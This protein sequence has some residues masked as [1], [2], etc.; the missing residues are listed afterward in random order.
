MRRTGLRLAALAALLFALPMAVL[1][2][3]PHQ[4]HDVTITISGATLTA[5]GKEAGLGD[6]D[7]VHIV[8]TATASCVNPGNNKP[9]AANKET[10]TAEGDFP[11]Q[12]GKADFT[13]SVTAT[14]QPSCS[15]PMTVEFSDV[16]VVDTT[17]GI[18]LYP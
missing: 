15:P 14:F 5:S 11:V 4:V 1:A 16:T 12:N 9:Q 18:Q 7:Q 6:E 3:S 2:G 10:L 17:N 13:L 8:L